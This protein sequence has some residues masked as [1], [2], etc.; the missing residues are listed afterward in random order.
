MTKVLYQYQ[1]EGN[2]PI[3]DSNN[4]MNLIES[5][6]P[7]LCGFFDILFQSINPTQKNQATK[8]LLRQKVMMLCY[9]IATLRNKQ[10]SGTKT[11]IGLFMV[12]SGTSKNGI[13]TLANM[14]MSLTYQTT[15]NTL[16]KKC[17]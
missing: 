1:K 3:F 13:N 5:Q 4:F 10:V 8:Q 6:D 7:K 11:A 16:K 17:R 15:Y 14:G 9:Q 2:L 12:E